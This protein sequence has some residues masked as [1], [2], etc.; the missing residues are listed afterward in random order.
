MIDAADRMKALG[1]QLQG[2]GTPSSI[3]G[4]AAGLAQ[5]IESEEQFRISV[6]PLICA[7]KPETAMGLAACLSYLVEQYRSTKVYRC[8]AKIDLND[9]SGEISPS[10]YQFSASEWE[11]AGLADN[12]LLYGTLETKSAGYVL[13]LALD[14]SLLN[15][16]ELE[17]FSLEFDSLADVVSALPRVAEQVMTS[18]AGANDDQ[19][20]I[21]YS[22]LS[23]TEGE[24][25]RLLASV[26]EWNLDVYLSFWDV[27][28]GGADRLAQY[29]EVSA[30][31]REHGS[32]FAAWCLGMMAKQ[33]MQVGLEEEGEVLVPEVFQ[34]FA[35]DVRA[36]PGVAAA[37]RGLSNLGYASRA[38]E[39]LEPYLLPE[40]DASAWSSMVDIQLAAGQFL[41]AIDTCQRALE[42]GL[43]H[44]A[45][46]WQYAEL[47][48][49]AEAHDRTVA[50]LL[51]VD[52]DEHDEADQIPLE[53]T[54]ALKLHIA[55]SPGNLRALQ[56]ALAYMI[57]TEDEELWRNFERLAQNDVAGEF[58]GDIIDRLVDLADHDRAYDVLERC[59]DANPYAHVYQAQLAL[60]D[61]DP[62]LASDTIEA[63]RRR[64]AKIDSDLDADLQRLELKSRLPEFEESFAEIKL[65]LSTNRQVTEEQVDLLEGAVEI[66]PSMIDLYLALSRCYLSW[67]DSESAYEVLGDAESRAG[68]HPQI[69]LVLAR[70]LWSRS[71][72]EEAIAKL[73]AA[74]DAFPG[75]VYLL[76]QM[77]NYLIE[78]D[79]LDDA[80]Q[81]I[82]RAETIAPS[83][84][85][86]WQVRR[87][88][89]QKLSQ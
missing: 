67:N 28:W 39:L 75:D 30:Y 41:D 9:D 38:S 17:E 53:I 32:G 86:I 7:E 80:R 11:L 51:L 65:L 52:P 45:L 13:N 18:L 14:L 2:E 78:N 12:V 43:E 85:A 58:V 50:E 34:S 64:F 25:E 87:L 23:A 59:L 82:L 46:Y 84:R 63:C 40:S 81:Y 8:F 70:I 57:D 29:R 16:S 36:S 26:F 60:A 73:N 79:Q 10:D 21:V 69:E 72:R 22:P 5:A 88:V 54:S 33:V 44:P 4:S 48:I 62:Q 61:D 35:S 66:S 31:S 47:L 76:V 77:A 19:A 83:H 24:L 27:E 89:A 74:L 68:A 49:N 20:I 15:S 37:A 56:L 1:K 3:F 6:Y 55:L 42:S 71:E